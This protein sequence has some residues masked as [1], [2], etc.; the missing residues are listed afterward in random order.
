M[1]Q[2]TGALWARVRELVLALE[3]VPLREPAAQAERDVVPQGLPA[4]FLDPVAL[5]PR[6]RMVTVVAG[7]AAG[8][9]VRVRLNPARR[10]EITLWRYAKPSPWARSRR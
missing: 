2:L 1:P 6:H 10:L 3:E 7:P 5:W 9:V 8:A 4:F